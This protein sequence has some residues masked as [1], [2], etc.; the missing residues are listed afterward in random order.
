MSRRS[1]ADP[2]GIGALPGRA[3]AGYGGAT[4][5]CTLKPFFPAVVALVVG[6]V[7]GAWQP[8]GELLAMRAELDEMRAVAAKP[9]RTDA[10]ASI[11]SLL[12]VDPEDLRAARDDGEPTEE[13]AVTAEPVPDAPDAPLDA[14]GAAPP[15]GEAPATP[16][17]ARAAA[18]AALDAR[19]SQAR[20]ALLEQADLGDD[21]A[22]AVDAAVDEMNRELKAEIDAFVDEAVA[23]GEIDRRAMMEFAAGALD[24]Y[25]AADDRFREA[26]PADVYGEIDP[27]AVDPLSYV[28]YDALTSIERA[29]G[30]PNTAFE[31]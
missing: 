12:Q 24:V 21:E 20:A 17:E 10:A 15:D 22:A 13:G 19:R 23:N 6:I 9:C 26:V 2:G 11:R 4:P 7:L 16:E 30:I 8:R 25:I 29:V 28:S 31:R 14:E 18:R 27:S 5:G 1:V 3:A